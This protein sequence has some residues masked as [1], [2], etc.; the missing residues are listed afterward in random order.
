MIQTVKA[1]NSIK[2][3]ACLDFRFSLKTFEFHRHSLFK[4]TVKYHKTSSWLF[5]I[6]LLI[7]ENEL[8][9]Y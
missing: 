1:T 2:L 7:Q 6:I 8:L 4:A 5:S 3:S 9:N